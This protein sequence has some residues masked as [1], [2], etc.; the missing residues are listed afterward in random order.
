MEL[1]G[2]H[3]YNPNKDDGKIFCSNE[4]YKEHYNKIAAKA[5]K[6]IF[7]GMAIIILIVAVAFIIYKVWKKKK[8]RY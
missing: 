6:N 2:I 4:C 1:R 5:A 7:I 3:F 8:K